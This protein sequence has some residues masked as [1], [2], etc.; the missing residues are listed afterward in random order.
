M[1]SFFAVKT[2]CVPF[3]HFCIHLATVLSQTLNSA[4]PYLQGHA[5]R[6]GRSGGVFERTAGK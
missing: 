1:L 5:G 3:S 2:K 4:Y 6:S